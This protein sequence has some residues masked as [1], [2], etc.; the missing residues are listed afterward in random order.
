MLGA[1]KA[2][3]LIAKVNNTFNSRQLPAI[4]G[5]NAAEKRAKERE[6]TSKEA[7]VT[8][9]KTRLHALLAAGR[10]DEILRD[11]DSYEPEAISDLVKTIS[12]R[13]SIRNAT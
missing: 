8:R 11:Y 3:G 9:D 1:H 12:R 13:Q 5:N 2:Y 6:K 4:D 7:A 10:T